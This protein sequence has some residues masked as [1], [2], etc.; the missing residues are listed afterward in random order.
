MPWIITDTQN[1]QEEIMLW[2]L[3][4]MLLRWFHRGVAPWQK[5]TS[6]VYILWTVCIRYVPGASETLATC[7]L[8][9]EVMY[10]QEKRWLKTHEIKNSQTPSLGFATVFGGLIKH[11]VFCLYYMD[12]V[13]RWAPFCAPSPAEHI[14][15]YL[16]KGASCLFQYRDE[17]CAVHV[18]FN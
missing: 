13:V 8:S 4:R 15:C 7:D 5:K 14:K 1:K 10:P 9:W 17:G 3:T 18:I 12:G 6:R 11:I 2:L 16:Y